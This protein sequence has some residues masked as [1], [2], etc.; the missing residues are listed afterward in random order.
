[1][2]KKKYHR[3]KDELITSLNDID[4]QTVVLSIEVIETSKI[5][6]YLIYECDYLDNGVQKKV[7]IIAKDI[8]EAMQK[9]EPYVGKGIP[10]TTANLILG[11]HLYQKVT[12]HDINI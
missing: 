7:N 6:D 1:M 11:N 4:R 12:D 3:N 9:L 2:L 10:D 5:R 8:T